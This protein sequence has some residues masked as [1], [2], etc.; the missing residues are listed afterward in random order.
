MTDLQASLREFLEQHDTMTLATIGPDREPRAAAVFYAVREELVLYFLS[1]PAS[2]HSENLARDSRVAATI[3]RDGQP[4]QEIR[5]LQIEGTAQLVTDEREIGQAARVFAARF[6]FL[7][8]LLA[9]S[10]SH[11]PPE[12]QGPLQNSRFFVLRP[13]W[14]RL[15][16]NTKGFGHKEEMTLIDADGG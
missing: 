2:R 1:N 16:D 11:G 6:A 5:G 14:I 3:Q 13:S 8:G 15:I 10:E 12:L 7:Q 9:D 4:W